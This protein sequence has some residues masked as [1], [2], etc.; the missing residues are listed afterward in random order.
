MFIALLPESNTFHRFLQHPLWAP[1]N[2]AQ[3]WRRLLGTLNPLW[4]HADVAARVV[5]MT[6]EAPGVRSLWLA[7]TAAFKGH[8]AGQHIVLGLDVNGVK[9]SRCFSISSQPRADR[10][11]R[12][13]IKAKPNGPVSGAA[14]QLRAGAVVELSQAFGDFAPPSGAQPLLL[15]G[16]GSGITPLL[17][18]AMA[19]AANHDVVLLR[20]VREDCDQLFTEELQTLS[21]QHP[22]LRVISHIRQRDGRLS[23][24]GLAALV[25]D[26]QSRQTMLCGPDGLM[27]E[28][29]SFYAAHGASAALQTESFGQR[30]VKPDPDA[31][32]HQINAQHSSTQFAARNGQTL[33]DAAEQ[34]GLQPKFGCRR[35]ICRTCQCRK[36][37]GTVLNTLTGLPSGAGSEL[38]QLCISTPQSAVELA[39]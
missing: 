13:T 12:L 2:D 25:P 29:E 34:A 17:P 7:P 21:A 8:R 16:V 11:I 35:G 30:A 39:L 10:L 14:H 24:D 6:D 26:W 4:A 32:S 18:I 33:L 38:I 19:Q 3:A 22:G 23:G 20:S 1:L 28:L 37:S 5:R 15:I 9:L 27:S 36:L 31:A